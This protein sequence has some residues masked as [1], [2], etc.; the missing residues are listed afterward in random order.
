MKKIIIGLIICL[1]I[2][3]VFVFNQKDED[4]LKYNHK[5]P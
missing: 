2:V 3:L 4:V 5:A 1:S